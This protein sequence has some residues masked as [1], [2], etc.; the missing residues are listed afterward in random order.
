MVGINFRGVVVECKE[1]GICLGSI[2]NR[3]MWGSKEI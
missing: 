1:N 3:I 2:M